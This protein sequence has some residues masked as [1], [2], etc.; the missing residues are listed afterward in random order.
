MANTADRSSGLLRAQWAQR[1]AQVELSDFGLV[2]S[3][4]DGEEVRAS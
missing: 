1:A 2:L 3:D 4:E